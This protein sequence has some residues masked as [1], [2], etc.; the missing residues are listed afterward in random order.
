[1]RNQQDV[2]LSKRL[3]TA[4][5]WVGLYAVIWGFGWWRPLDM[6]V[7]FVIVGALIV[8]QVPP[9]PLRA[10][11]GMAAYVAVAAVLFFAV[12]VRHP[13]PLLLLGIG[14][15]QC[16]IE[17]LTALRAKPVHGEGEIRSN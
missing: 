2:P 13:L 4:L 11:V 9:W 7:N 17:G 14:A 5:L 16:L 15:I 6:W 1:M 3:L 10:F 8:A 12:N